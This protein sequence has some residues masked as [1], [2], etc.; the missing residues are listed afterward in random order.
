MEGYEGLVT[1]R[2]GRPPKESPMK[3][4]TDPAPLTELEREELIRLR[5]EVE[6]LKA[7]NIWW[8]FAPDGRYS[9]ANDSWGK[10]LQWP[11]SSRTDRLYRTDIHPKFLCF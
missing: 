9:A 10:Q 11:A 1:E 4:K 6:Y 7:E 3:K 8:N 5:A 2:K